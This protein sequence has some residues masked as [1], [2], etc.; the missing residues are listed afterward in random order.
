MSSRRSAARAAGGGG[1]ERLGRGHPHLAHRERDAERHRRRV[2]RAGVAVGR[3][4]DG[5][6]GV[7]QPA[8]VRVRRRGWR[9]RRRAAAW[10]RWCGRTGE[11]VDVGV[12]AGGCSGRRWPRPARPRAARPAP[13]PSWLAC[14]RGVSPAAMPAVRMCP[15]LVDVEGAA[16]AEHVDP[17]GVRRAACQHRPADQLDVVVAV[18]GG[19]RRERRARRGTWSRR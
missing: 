6:A 11:R 1:P 19:T 10:P 16:L 15:G 12:G 14:T 9:T 18:V 13:G 5:H 4:R 17:P 3:Q 2:R 7:E 8:G